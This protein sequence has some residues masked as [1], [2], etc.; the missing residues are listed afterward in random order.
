MMFPVATEASA[1]LAVFH[2]LPI[3]IIR[4]AQVSVCFTVLA[5]VGRFIKG[6]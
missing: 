1:F 4:L 6:R 2:S 5:I 3:P